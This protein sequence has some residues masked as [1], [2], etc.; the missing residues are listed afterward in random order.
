MTLP[1]VPS[2]TPLV[3][4][5]RHVARVAAHV[6]DSLPVESCGLM[7]G[8]DR[9]VIEVFPV[10]NVAKYPETSYL[11]EPHEQVRVMALLEACRWELVAI[12]HSHPPGARS[13]PSPLDMAQ[14]NYPGVPYVIVVPDEVG[15]IA[16]LRAFLLDDPRRPVEVPVVVERS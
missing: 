14:A 12:Y 8:T 3:L 7:G 9:R 1:S 4:K 16:S 10:P 6:R 13:D 5:E 15:R 11:M 2:P